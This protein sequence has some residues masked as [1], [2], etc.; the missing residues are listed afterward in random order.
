VYV[1]QPAV[2]KV[3]EVPPLTLSP[4]AP[5]ALR[6]EGMS[7]LPRLDKAAYRRPAVPGLSP[8]RKDPYTPERDCAAGPRS[9]R[10]V[11][12]SAL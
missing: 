7:A 2:V 11:A 3:F 6:G 4:Y 12:G 9:L 1:A 5:M 10:T 8:V